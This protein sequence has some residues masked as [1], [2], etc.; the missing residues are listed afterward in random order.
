MD[1]Q[2]RLPSRP[3]ALRLPATLGVKLVSS[4][5]IVTTL[6]T[7]ATKGPVQV[8]RRGMLRGFVFDGDVKAG[9]PDGG[10]HQT[11]IINSPTF[12]SHN[13]RYFRLSQGIKQGP[14]EKAR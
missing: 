11:P 2:P 9:N 10:H 7:G 6:A 13:S 3:A 12:I 4:S 14:N 5:E 8:A 1:A